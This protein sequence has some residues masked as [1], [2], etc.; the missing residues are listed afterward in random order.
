[1]AMYVIS[2][3]HGC[4][5]RLMKM[6]EIIEFT[7]EDHLIVAGDLMD[8]GNQNKEIFEWMMNAPNNIEF[9]LGN[10]D[11][12][13]MMNV[14]FLLGFMWTINDLQDAYEEA[15]K[16]RYFFDRYRTLEKLIMVDKVSAEQIQTWADRILEFPFY[17]KLEIDE[18]KFVVVH[19]AYVEG[20]QLEE[21]KQYG[22]DEEHIYIWER[23][24]TF[25]FGCPDTTIIYGHT[26][27]ISESLMYTGGIVHIM[28]RPEDH[29]RFIDIDCG[30][31]FM[32]QYP[33]ANMACIRL[34]DEKIFYLN[35]DLANVIMEEQEHN[36]N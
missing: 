12:E 4:Y 8:R 31:V 21:L 6:L 22:E 9:I 17:K 1:M 30:A 36:N 15:K 34:E 32:G 10:H 18:K 5:D 2:D 16:R 33:G 23:E 14:D 26:P 27:T 11:Q 29:C 13:F 3:L 25:T 35:E 28:E 20:E 7:K 24:R 19:A